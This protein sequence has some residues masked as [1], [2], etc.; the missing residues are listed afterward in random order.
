MKADKRIGEKMMRIERRW[1]CKNHAR[2][3]SAQY[4]RVAVRYARQDAKRQIRDA[5]E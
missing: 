3:A 1:L 4:K 5:M 2:T